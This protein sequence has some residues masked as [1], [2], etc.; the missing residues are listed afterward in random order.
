M[1]EWSKVDLGDHRLTWPSATGPAQDAELHLT[2]VL[3]ATAR[4][5]SSV[6]AAT[7]ATRSWQAM[8]QTSSPHRCAT[9]WEAICFQAPVTSLSGQ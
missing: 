1:P 6:I 5:G 3:V 9:R 7:V 8:C 4:I 2:T